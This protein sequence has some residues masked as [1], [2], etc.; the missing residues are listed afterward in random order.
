M[1]GAIT[2]FLLFMIS[3]VFSL[4]AYVLV[5][6]L[7]LQATGAPFNNP[8]SQVA[9]TLTKPI[10]PFFQR[11]IPGYKGVDFSLVALLIIVAFIRVELLFFIRVLSFPNAL[12]AFVWAVGWAG[13]CV[14]DVLFF[15]VIV[16]A[17]VSW[18]PSIQSSPVAEVL[19]YLAQPVLA[20]CRRFIP[21]MGGIDFSPLVA[22]VAIKA[23]EMLVFAPLIS[24]GTQ[25]ALS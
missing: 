16:S 4:Y 25:L 15:S 20:P 11:F 13:D 7:F 14:L 1:G 8:I 18:V 17:V 5:M 2:N 23:I 21:L 6:R 10:L 9:I 24:S 12:G 22:L 19:A 3:V